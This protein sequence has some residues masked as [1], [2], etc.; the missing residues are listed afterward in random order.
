MAGPVFSPLAL[1]D[2]Q[3]IL[4]YISRDNPTAP[5]PTLNSSRRS[6]KHL[7]AIRFWVRHGTHLQK[8]CVCFRSATT[9]YTIGLNSRPFGSC[10]CC[11]AHVTPTDCLTEYV[12]WH[13]RANPSQAQPDLQRVLNE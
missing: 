9:R 5:F 10:E 13:D 7:P 8:D 2:L 11:M 12:S 1:K 4:E 6:A 3:D